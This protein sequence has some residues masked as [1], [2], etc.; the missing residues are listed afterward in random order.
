[1]G[2]FCP[3][4]SGS[5]ASRPKWMRM[6]WLGIYTKGSDFSFWQANNSKTNCRSETVLNLYC[7]LQ[8][9][10]LWANMFCFS[11]CSCLCGISVQE[12]P[13]YRMSGPYCRWGKNLEWGEE[14]DTINMMETAGYWFDKWRLHIDLLWI[15]LFFVYNRTVFSAGKKVATPLSWLNFAKL[16][17]Y[18][19]KISAF[20][21][22]YLEVGK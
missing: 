19:G 17:R 18:W 7:Y 10:Y 8:I 22:K 11:I 6:H 4:G 16:C 3:P 13:L 9:M 21:E 1:M 5:G 2:N 12:A 14:N 15:L 20:L